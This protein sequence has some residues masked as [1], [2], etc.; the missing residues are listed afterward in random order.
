M[1]ESLLKLKAQLKK[2]HHSLTIWFNTVGIVMLTAA[3]ADPL[4]AT[5]LLDNGFTWILII[6]NII[7]RFRTAKALEDK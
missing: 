3:M 2:A 1:K 4:V 6:G 5:F 7:I